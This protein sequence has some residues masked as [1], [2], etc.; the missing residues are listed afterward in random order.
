MCPG[1]EF[2]LPS[3]QVLWMAKQ[4]RRCKQENDGKWRSCPCQQRCLIP[5]SFSG[6]HVPHVQRTSV[7]EKSA[8][9]NVIKTWCYRH[10]HR[11]KIL[12]RSTDKYKCFPSLHHSP[13]GNTTPPCSLDWASCTELQGQCM[14]DWRGSVAGITTTSS[15]ENTSDTSNPLSSIRMWQAHTFH[16][17]AKWFRSPIFNSVTN[18]PHLKRL[19][20]VLACLKIFLTKSIYISWPRSRYVEELSWMESKFLRPLKRPQVSAI[21]S[22]WEPNDQPRPCVWDFL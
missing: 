19:A 15:G 22:S 10:Q 11:I 21:M 16:A 1:C 7:E 18:P 2:P 6:T 8:N 4:K 20:H 3:I 13:T 17:F 5:F 9:E 14:Q 12:H